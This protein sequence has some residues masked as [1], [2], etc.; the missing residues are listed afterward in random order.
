MGF[1]SSLSRNSKDIQ[2][3]PEASTLW[4]G[5][6]KMGPGTQA[7]EKGAAGNCGQRRKGG[8][9]GRHLVTKSSSEGEHWEAPMGRGSRSTI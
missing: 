9:A 4:G 8:G 1:S 5:G 6:E 2:P 3:Y 7:S